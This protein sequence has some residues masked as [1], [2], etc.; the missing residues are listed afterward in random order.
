MKKRSIKQ[1]RGFTLIELLVVVLIIGILAAVAVPQYKKAVYKSRYATMKNLVRSIADAQEVYYLANNEYADDFDKLDVTVPDNTIE[2]EYAEDENA[3][4][5][6]KK[7]RW[8]DWGYCSIITG[9]TASVDCQNEQISM[10]YN[11]RLLH[12]SAVTYQGKPMCIALGTNDVS[13]IQNQI[14]K[15]ET[16]LE[17]P[18]VKHTTGDI[19]NTWLYP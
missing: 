2:H 15:Q 3:D 5:L 13:T 12:T 9:N 10:R 4:T 19:Y 17:K 11:I 18:T 14:C 1:F 8:Y 16:L 6:S 7:R